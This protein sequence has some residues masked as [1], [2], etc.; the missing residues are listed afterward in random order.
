MPSNEAIADAFDDA[1][2]GPVGLRDDHV[3]R[4][5]LAMGLTNEPGVVAQRGELVD[6]GGQQCVLQEVRLGETLG[7]VGTLD[8]AARAA[9]G[10]FER[11]VGEEDGSVAC[12]DCHQGGQKVERLETNGKWRRL[13]QALILTPGPALA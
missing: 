12:D 6:A 2:T 13:G 4:Q 7:K 8:R 10:V 9:E 11:R 1:L 5:G 3:N